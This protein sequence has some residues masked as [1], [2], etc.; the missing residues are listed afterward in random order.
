MVPAITGSDCQGL[1]NC[2]ALYCDSQYLLGIC[3]LKYS[4]LF[5][6]LWIRAE[7]SSSAAG[8]EKNENI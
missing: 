4:L 6:D 7:L 5:L 8:W 3:N 2:A 1:G